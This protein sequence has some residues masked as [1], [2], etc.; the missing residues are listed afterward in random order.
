[1]D[2]NIL[3]FLLLLFVINLG[4]QLV[5]RF[6]EGFMADL[7]YNLL[8]SADAALCGYA[9]SSPDRLTS[10]WSWLGIGIF[11]GAVLI[12][13][14]LALLTQFAM[15]KA[16]WDLATHLLSIKQVF[17]PSR[18]GRRQLDHVARLRKAHAGHV[19]EIE[20]DLLSEISR[21]ADP[22]GKRLMQE[23]LLELLAFSG[24]WERCLALHE[25]MVQEGMTRLSR[26]TL[27]VALIRA[28]LESRDAVRIWAFYRELQKFD[29]ADPTVSS[30]LLSSEIMLLAAYGYS[31]Q[32]ERALSPVH[33][34]HPVF[35]VSSKRYW[36]GLAHLQEGNLEKASGYLQFP[37]ALARENP[38]LDRLARELER[39]G[40]EK[41]TLPTSDLEKELD[42]MASQVPVRF[43]QVRGPKPP[44]A[45]GLFLGGML[46]AFFAQS[47]LGESDDLWTLYQL[48]ANFRALSVFEEPW[49]LVMAMFLHAGLIHLLLNGLMMFMFGRI[50][51]VHFG[52]LRTMAVFVFSGI[53]G[54]I[55]S[56]LIYRQ[57]LS[58]GASS[59]VFGMIGAVLMM[60]VIARD[61][62][63]PVWRKKQ[64]QNL[65]FLLLLNLLL[66]FSMSMI[67]NAAHIG[68]F[69]G[70]TFL[71]WFFLVFG[72]TGAWR[73]WVLR[74][75]GIVACLLVVFSV[76]QVVRHQGKARLTPMSWRQG[77]YEIS[78]TAPVF[79]QAGVES[80]QNPM[81][82]LMPTVSVNQAELPEGS[83]TEAEVIE[84]YLVQHQAQGKKD[85]LTLLERRLRPGWTEVEY[86]FTF[87]KTPGNEKIFI[88][89]E[90]R[91][92][93]VL[94]FVYDRRCG[95]SVHPFIG[96]VADSFRTQRFTR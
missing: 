55:A 39:R 19:E 57:G 53:T 68:G 3:R 31:D 69:L 87:E 45:T 92:L 43:A 61:L 12:P 59:T 96:S 77:G 74:G 34:N 78:M 52:F 24:Q 25:R 46:V 8:L 79:W 44:I 23:T 94:R 22:A 65:V 73:R 70:G 9:L 36:L 38:I 95:P 14:I 2:P 37:P 82:K 93:W 30:A 67:D 90:D 10:I 11:I 88:K 7:P 81:C 89:V 5:R 66:G 51:E 80:L 33:R 83:R 75:L 56:A 4:F 29:Q 58:V 54:N 27:A 21:A 17:A 62:W 84:Q 86:S 71:G 63:H 35:P 42:R 15:G 16:R 1:M 85:S 28:S 26:P 91:M 32:L 20:R 40:T 6:R 13:G 76:V 48:G 18:E 72:S 49:R 47:W 50:L 60:F 41:L 64:I